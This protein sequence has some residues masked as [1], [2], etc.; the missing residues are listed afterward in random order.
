[1][2]F[3]TTLVWLGWRHLN[4]V[5]P[6]PLVS[7]ITVALV[8]LAST[9]LTAGLARTPLSKALTG[10]SRPSPS[11][12]PPAEVTSSPGL[13]TPMVPRP[14]TTGARRRRQRRCVGTRPRWDG[15][16]GRAGGVRTPK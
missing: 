14:A 2:I 13:V 12:A 8:V 9:G 5:L 10:R 1:M 15:G 3:I 16:S 7:V 11:P 6:W 4:G